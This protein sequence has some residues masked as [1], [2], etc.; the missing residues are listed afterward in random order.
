VRKV[1]VISDLQAPFHHKRAVRALERYIDT[2]DVDD[3]ILCVGDEIDQPGISRWSK[4][5]KGE[6]M[7]E[8]GRHRDQTVDILGRLQVDHVSRSN[9]SDRLEHYVDRFA[10]GLSGLPELKYEAFMR[11]PE[12]GIT[13]HRTPYRFAKGWCLLHGDEGRL[14][15]MAGQTA[16][17]LAMQRNTSVVCGHS[18]R[19]GVAHHTYSIAGN[20]TKKVWGLEVGT[21]MDTRSSG[22]SYT[23]GT[24]NWSLSFGIL[25]LDDRDRVRAAFPVMMEKDG[26][27]MV[28]GKVWAA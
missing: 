14:S 21:L 11:F 20:V 24:T 15:P 17:K 16:L 1:V 25:H 19:A 23:G 28:D 13:Y 7:G 6:F 18:H 22:A 26:S 9:H 2:M 10:P 8:L 3:Q 5:L 12:L 4:G 27:F